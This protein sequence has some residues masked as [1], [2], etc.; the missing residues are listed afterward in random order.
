MNQSEHAIRD[1]HAFLQG[2]LCSVAAFTR[3]KNY[4]V[5]QMCAPV[6]ETAAGSFDYTFESHL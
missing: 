6:D 2:S 3:A 5:D 4:C 1:S